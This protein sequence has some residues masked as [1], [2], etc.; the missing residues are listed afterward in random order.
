MAASVA[1]ACV[2]LLRYSERRA[3]G[4]VI[5]PSRMFVYK[6]ARRLLNWTGDSGVQFRAALKAIV[7]FG[8]PAERY[9]P[10]DPASLDTEP[11]A[12]VYSSARRFS[13]MCYVRL[14]SRQHKGRKTLETVRSFLAAG[15]PCVLGFPVASSLSADAEIPCP[16]VFD[17]LRG[18]QGAVAV[19]YD[20]ARRTRAGKGALLLSLSWGTGWGDQGYGWLP[21]AFVREQLAADF[22]TVLKPDWLASGEFQWPAQSCAGPATR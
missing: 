9:W 11:D 21:Y 8:I 14:D 17:V 5:E 20:D 4:K 12:F 19:G 2:A 15:F 3:T 1:H 6:T 13:S 7:R 18:G 10:Y 22:W 16:T